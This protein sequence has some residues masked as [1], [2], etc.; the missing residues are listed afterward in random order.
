MNY[1]LVV[2]IEIFKYEVFLSPIIWILTV[3]R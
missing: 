2:K 3:G 1:Y